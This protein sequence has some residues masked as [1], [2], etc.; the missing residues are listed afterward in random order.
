MSPILSRAG[1]EFQ[2]SR[3]DAARHDHRFC[4]RLGSC[5][6]AVPIKSQMLCQLS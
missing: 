4:K 5:W 6:V 1:S 2:H 3:K